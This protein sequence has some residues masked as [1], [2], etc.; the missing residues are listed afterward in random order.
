MAHNRIL[1]VHQSAEMY[2]SDK[3]LLDLIVGLDQQRYQAVILLPEEGVLADKL[4]D[5]GAEVYIGPVS[6]ISRAT[7]TPLGMLRFLRETF[8]S[9]RC[10][11]RIVGKQKPLL[12][13]SNTLAV[14][15]GAV[16]AWLNRV[17]HLWHVH[18]IILSPNLA[19]KMFPFLLRLFADRVVC[20]SKATAEWVVGEQPKLKGITSVVWNGLSDSFATSTPSGR[21][22]GELGIPQDSVL[23]GL[24]G[25]INTWKGHT[26]LLRAAEKLLARGV[27]D[28]SVLFVGGVFP[29]Y[30][31]VK[32]DLLREI[33]RSP[34]KEHMRI[35]DFHSNISEIWAEMDIGAVP[36]TE[37]EPFGVVALEAMASGKPV[38]AAA[39]GGLV[40]IVVPGETGILFMPRDSDSLADALYELVTDAEKR[41]R[42]GEAGRVRQQKIF[43]FTAY[44]NAFHKMYGEIEMERAG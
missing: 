21:V 19:K 1:F 17:P 2:G 28:F 36:S 44:V 14:F 25:R 18:E 38:V 27:A 30:E 5:T 34:A 4:R 40:D 29:G 39:H 42:L 26:L 13:H 6:K 32:E 43:S 33:D 23:I 9:C 7:L 37:P 35:L 11:S 8:R 41:Q 12:V 31:Y 24:V 15:G 20:N 3:V 22:R 16:W 10:I